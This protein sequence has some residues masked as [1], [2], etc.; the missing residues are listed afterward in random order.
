VAVKVHLNGSWGGSNSGGGAIPNFTVGFDAPG[1][2][3]TL[4]GTVAFVANPRSLTTGAATG[5]FNSFITSVELWRGTPASPIAKLG[6]MTVGGFGYTYNYN[7]TLLA[8]GSYDFHAKFTLTDASVRRTADLYLPISN[9]TTAP[10]VQ[11]DVHSQV[12]AALFTATNVDVETMEAAWGDAIVGSKKFVKGRTWAEW[13]SNISAEI[14]QL[15]PQGFG[16]ARRLCPYLGPQNDTLVNSITSGAN[17]TVTTAQS[18]EI[19]TGDTIV[20]SGVKAGSSLSKLNGRLAIP[21]VR[22]SSTSFTLQ[23]VSF[24]GSYDSSNKGSAFAGW[25][26]I[27]MNAGRF[28]TYYRQVRDYLLAKLAGMS[29]TNR[30]K[31]FAN[32]MWVPWHE[33]DGSWYIQATKGDKT[34]DGRTGSYLATRNAWRRMY[35][36]LMY[37]PSGW[38]GTVQTTAQSGSLAQLYGARAMKWGYEVANFDICVA[39][40]FE[41]WPG[42]EYVDAVF[43]NMYCLVYSTQS[44][45]VWDGTAKPINGNAAQSVT[46]RGVALGVLPT[47]YLTD[48]KGDCQSRALEWLVAWA[49]NTNN[50]R[51]QYGGGVGDTRNLQVG[52]GE[53]SPSALKTTLTYISDAIPKQQIQGVYDWAVAN[54]ANLHSIN[55]FDVDKAEGYFATLR[56]QMSRSGST[57]GLAA[58]SNYKS[59]TGINTARSATANRPAHRPTV[60]DK[61]LD[62]FGRRS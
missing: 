25:G 29:S 2:T 37:E 49:K 17:P 19:Q 54:V 1:A 9:G 44:A 40:A 12:R 39:D 18:M 28:D 33:L 11:G 50:V 27:E 56:T 35:R 57:H 48:G 5:E 47:S 20:F 10:P 15:V 22:N 55:L 23:G 60:S 41:P 31:W 30:T 21:V 34:Y 4:Q 3:A 8:D 43:M 36:I 62:V 53:W 46:Q 13:V 59:C 45:N 24:E 52:I 61:F 16:R 32:N 38:S 58:D 14:D 26:Q 42:D 6:D 7:T 51:R